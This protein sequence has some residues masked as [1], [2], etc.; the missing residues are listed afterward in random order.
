MKD[1]RCLLDIVA[2]EFGSRFE[3]RDSRFEIRDS[4]FAKGGDEDCGC[5][6]GLPDSL[7][8]LFDL[9]CIRDRNSTR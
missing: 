9:K 4:S 5:A 6:L 8:A 1:I 2:G 3:I 7:R